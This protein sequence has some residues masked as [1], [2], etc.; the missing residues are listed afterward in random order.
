M[1]NRNFIYTRDGSRM[2]GGPLTSGREEN[3]NGRQMAKI[4]G[5]ENY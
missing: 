3:G 5:N 2:I 1:G 4:G